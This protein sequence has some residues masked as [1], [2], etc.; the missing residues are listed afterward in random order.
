MPTLD[1]INEQN[2]LL[3]AYRQR[4][5]VSLQQRAV[6]G[7]ANVPPSV[8]S[9]IDECR[10][11]IRRIK[12]V[13][14]TWGVS[15]EDHPDDEGISITEPQPK[16]D[17]DREYRLMKDLRSNDKATVDRAIIALVNLNVPSLLDDVKPFVTGDDMSLASTTLHALF[18]IP[19]SHTA[20]IIVEGLRSPFS[21][22]RRRTVY[23]MGETAYLGKRRND[24]FTVVDAL[25][26]MLK[27]PHEDANILDEAVHAIAK[28]GGEQAL[29]ALITVL[30]DSNMS[31][32]LKARALHGPGRF[33]HTVDPS[34][35]ATFHAQA[36]QSIRRWP[37]DVCEQVES[38]HI[39]PYIDTS[40]REEVKAR[41]DY[42]RTATS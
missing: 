41:R 11:E 8:A 32:S 29:T 4:L 12:Q 30:N 10:T 18:F 31:P 39:F 21:E 1:D 9:S 19:G 26:E 15:V 34:H 38:V 2:Q 28:I 22:I 24:M 13:L 37:H 33:W 36:I 16:R 35:Y 27:N 25:I 5:V 20:R 17:L 23:Q 7:S 42:L 40:L 6:H 14:R 3:Q